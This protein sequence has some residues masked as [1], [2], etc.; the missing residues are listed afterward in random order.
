MKKTPLYDTHVAAGAKLIDFGGWMMPVQYTS[1]IDEHMAVR[2]RAGIFDVSHMGEILIEGRDAES[3]LQKILTNDISK[4]QKGQIV[5]SPICYPDGGVVD[6]VLVYKLHQERFLVVANAANID[7]DYEWFL[8]HKE[9]EVDVKDVSEEY[10]QLAV[11]GPNAEQILN[12]LIDF[13]F[14]RIKFFRFADDIVIDGAEMLI[15]RTGYTGEDGFEIYISPEHVVRLWHSI[16]DIGKDYG[17]MPA[18]LGARDTLRF[19]AALPLYGHEISKD[20]SPLEG[21]LEK[22]VKFDKEN[23][24]GK[25]AL[26][27]QME[28]GIERRLVGF[29]MLD[30][31]IAREGYEVLSDDIL[32][33]YVTSGSY[34]PSLGKN[35]G[36]ALIKT[37][38]DIKDGELEI[39]VRK[40]RLK[41]KIVKL[42]FYTKQYRK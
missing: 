12:N 21:G 40:R 42:P 17:I 6:D 41:A 10:A 2:E 11:Q 37:D 39:V 7:K 34:S 1:I 33:G 25:D 23:F 9:G 27:S 19:E 28:R 32:I 5:Y 13:D 4:T 31:G 18:G 14:G 22:F 30:R 26:V 36:I 24:I 8:A 16:M 35:L 15:S 20:I 3:F 38:A 29:E